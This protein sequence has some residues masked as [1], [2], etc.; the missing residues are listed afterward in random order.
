MKE[1][2][3]KDL[4]LIFNGS[5][6]YGARYDGDQLPEHKWAWPTAT[7]FQLRLRQKTK[8]EQEPIA[9]RQGCS[10]S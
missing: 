4:E 8:G 6:L 3:P 1:R 7:W 9:R 10:R 5:R 2:R